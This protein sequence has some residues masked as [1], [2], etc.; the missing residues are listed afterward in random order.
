M[1]RKLITILL[2]GTICL[3]GV[4]PVLAQS[5][6]GYGTITEYEKATGK[7]IEKF[8]EAPALRTKVAAGEL[9]PVEERLP[10]EPV[11]M[12]PVEE[13]GQYGG[14]W[15]RGWTGPS[16]ASGLTGKLMKQQLIKW[17]REATKIIP[18][19][20][21]GWEVSEDR[22]VYTFYLREGMKWSDGEPFTADDYVFY[23]DDYLL[24]KEVYPVYPQF[25]MAGGEPAKVEKVNDYTVRF[26]FATPYVNFL[27]TIMGQYGLY[28]PKHYL[29]Q[30]HPRYTS[31]DE[32]E[33]MMKEEGFT[34]WSQLYLSKRPANHG[35]V[36]NPDLP[37]IW[38]WI[39]VNDLTTQR[40]IM[41]RNPYFW[42][43][44][45][46]G[47]QLPYIDRVA[48][49][50]VEST[51]MIVFK[52]MSGELDFQARHIMF[53]DYVL[54]KENEEKGD[55]RVLVWEAVDGGNP[56]LKLNL[57]CKDPV[58]RKIFE[59]KRFRFALSLAI[60]RPEINEFCW[61][62]M[63]KPRQASITPTGRYYSREW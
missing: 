11:V 59:D 57:T 26:R 29:K 23:H 52:A 43:V 45:T 2:I 5:L 7:K 50:L 47:N 18:N 42:K 48:N 39:P 63:A 55:Y 32:L 17:N 20:A 49:E 36:Y 25:L 35:E 13:V 24:N 15:K 12:I 27:E 51:E 3:L 14:T 30:F 61:L 34:S 53:K 41:E 6:W 9:P 44:D 8:N 58:L 56:H 60:N 22:R 1:M 21:K 54:F 28:A 62:G 38:A 31:M 46:E 40:F 4:A 10:R 33:K 37:C 16:D 19:I